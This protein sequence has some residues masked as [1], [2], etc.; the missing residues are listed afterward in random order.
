MISPNGNRQYKV[1]Y[2][3][4]ELAVSVYRL[5]QAVASTAEQLKES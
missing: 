1:P 2:Q 5:L 4:F 3:T